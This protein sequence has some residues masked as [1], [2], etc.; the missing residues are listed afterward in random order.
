M[1]GWHGARVAVPREGRAAAAQAGLG[2]PQRRPALSIGL[3]MSGSYVGSATVLF[4]L[5]YTMFG[6]RVGSLA[7]S[8]A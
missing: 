2:R 4:T 1:R 7:S 3:R 6:A 5:Q 8:R